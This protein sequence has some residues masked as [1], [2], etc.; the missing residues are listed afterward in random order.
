MAEP[1][2]IDAIRDDHKEVAAMLAQVAKERNPS[3]F[4]QLVH[5]IVVH[6][7]CGTRN[8]ASAHC[9]DVWREHVAEARLDEEARGT[10]AFGKL[11]EMGVDDPGF[12]AARPIVS[13]RCL[14]AR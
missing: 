8:R 7:T 4:A 1:D 14:R 5:K 2:L 13:A 9:P 11:Q 6:E 3:K 12:V 10:D